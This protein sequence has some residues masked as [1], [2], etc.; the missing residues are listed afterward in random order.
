[1]N[2]ALAVDVSCPVGEEHEPSSA[3]WSGGELR[4]WTKQS[5]RRNLQAHRQ[6]AQDHKYSG[7]GLT[8]PYFGAETCLLLYIDDWEREC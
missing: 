4:D 2:A 7:L 3:Q 8:E 6:E 5:A 1:M